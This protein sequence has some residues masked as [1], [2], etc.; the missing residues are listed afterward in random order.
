MILAEAQQ[1]LVQHG[2]ESK[3]MARLL[4]PLE[5]EEWKGMVNKRR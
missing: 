1:G 2:R 3:K 4:L 5:R